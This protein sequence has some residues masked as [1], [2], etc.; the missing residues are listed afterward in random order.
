MDL[1]KFFENVKEKK[2]GMIKLE[3]LVRIT[4][5]YNC[6]KVLIAAHLVKE[7]L[8]TVEEA[9]ESIE[10]QNEFFILSNN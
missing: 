9:A 4:T 8:I 1:K 7:G 2:N 10:E 6:R 3:D 5:P